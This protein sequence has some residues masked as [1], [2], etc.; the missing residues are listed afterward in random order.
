MRSC[1]LL[2]RALAPLRKGEPLLRAEASSDECAQERDRV[3]GKS[4]QALKKSVMYQAAM[5][6]A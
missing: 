2:L 3:G 4:V 5:K 6:S 1:C